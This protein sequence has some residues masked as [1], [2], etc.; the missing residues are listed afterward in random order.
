MH[1]LSGSAAPAFSALSLCFWMSAA[2]AATPAGGGAEKPG[3]AAATVAL[4][5]AS[6]PP[7]LGIEVEKT[8]GG[9]AKVSEI[10]PESPCKKIDLRVGDI[11]TAVS[12]RPVGS[13]TELVAAVRAQHVGQRVVLTIRRGPEERHTFLVTLTPRVEPST[14]QRR[15][16]LDNPAPE[17][18]LEALSGP[19]LSDGAAV[20]RSLRGSP[21]LL[22]FFATWCQPCLEAIPRLS[23]LERKYKDQ[24]LRVIGVSDEPK[25]LVLGT[26]TPLAPSYT[27]A[28]DP[29]QRARRAYR[30][31]AFP[32]L[33]LVDKLGT[34]RAI[35]GTDFGA[36]ERAISDVIE[37]RDVMPRPAP[38]AAAPS[39][40]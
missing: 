19:A 15:T 38:K 20:L 9:G 28:H 17:L 14:L 4:P 37:G 10:L 23:A 11:I 32:A 6:G 27:I 12:D 36:I 22:D 2:A 25:D 5:I 18:S 39:R 7:W 21:V 31:F 26:V 24:G 40:P 3:G 29:T 13:P 30:V 8:P 33:I 34:V 35:G 1:R 16:L